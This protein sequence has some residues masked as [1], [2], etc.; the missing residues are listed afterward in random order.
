MK[1]LIKWFFIGIIGL[2]AISVMMEQGSSTSSTQNETKAKETQ[3]PEVKTKE[4]VKKETDKEENTFSSNSQP[5]TNSGYVACLKEGLLDQIIQ[6]ANRKDKN[7][8]N[9]LLKHG[10]FFLKA[11]LPV[12]ILDTTWTGKAK[13]R[14]YVGNKAIEVWTVKEAISY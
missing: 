4:V 12:T 8:W 3:K 9:Y 6:A 5:I 1:K 10:C 2:A 11:G 7:A 14:V 13:I